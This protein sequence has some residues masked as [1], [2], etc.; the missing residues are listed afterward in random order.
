[1]SLHLECNMFVLDKLIQDNVPL[2]KITSY[3]VL[4]HVLD[5]GLTDKMDEALFNNRYEISMFKLLILRY[6]PEKFTNLIKTTYRKS[7]KD[8]IRINNVEL[9]KLV[10]VY[11]TPDYHNTLIDIIIKI[12][13]VDILNFI[14]NKNVDTKDLKIHADIQNMEMVRVMLEHGITISEEELVKVVNDNK[15]E[16]FRLLIEYKTPIT[17]EIWSNVICSGNLVMLRCLVHHG[18]AKQ[19]NIY[20]MD[21]IHPLLNYEGHGSEIY[22]AIK[23]LATHMSQQLLIKLFT[24]HLYHDIQIF[25]DSGIQIQDYPEIFVKYIENENIEVIEE[26]ISHGVEAG[27]PGGFATLHY[28]NGAPLYTAV[29]NDSEPVVQLL[30]DNGV[31]P[32]LNNNQA[33]RAAIMYKHLNCI[34]LLS[35]YYTE[36]PHAF[37]Y[38]EDISGCKLESHLDFNLQPREG[39]MLGYGNPFDGYVCLYLS[40]LT[41]QFVNQDFR[42]PYN[43]NQVFTMNDIH[44]ISE[45]IEDNNVKFSE[46]DIDNYTVFVINYEIQQGLYKEDVLKL[47]QIQDK[48]Y[49]RQLFVYLFSIGMYYRQWKGPGHKYPLLAKETGEEFTETCIEE[50]HF[51]QALGIMNNKY[52]LAL[53][54]LRKHNGEDVYNTY[55]QLYSRQIISGSLL[56]R[57]SIQTMYE[58]TMIKGENCIRVSSSIFIITGAYYLKVILDED[59]PGYS[60]DVPVETIH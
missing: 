54:E 39:P 53:Q 6:T 31:N 32:L 10:F 47:R 11:I 40:E 14:F 7:F 58:Q 30:L 55:Q 46:S 4:K 26:F 34:Y 9:F 33:Y 17:S 1:M 20:P 21:N 38:M 49:L 41:T 35:K 2:D 45:I 50:I 8:I 36:Q 59:I 15:L 13:A 48:T 42:N 56:Q 3:I 37:T 29:C 28:N 22:P 25:I 5:A 18:Y 57:D 12:E 24:T 44:D 51:L 60:L 43:L 27:D 52:T 19:L 16:F 23:I